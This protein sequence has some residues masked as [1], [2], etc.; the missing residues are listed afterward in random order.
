M[1]PGL[2]APDELRHCAMD[3]EADL[4]APLL[5]GDERDDAESS[6]T[7]K[8]S[9]E[10]GGSSGDVRQNERQT[11]HAPSTSY[12]AFGSPGDAFISEYSGPVLCAFHFH[13]H[14]AAPSRGLSDGSRSDMF[15]RDLLCLSGHILELFHR[16][17]AQGLFSPC[18][19]A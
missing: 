17:L 18:I 10:N 3:E 11:A 4:E 13:K 15:V 8:K 7:N 19:L 16:G 2:F 5:G 1:R 9:L 12:A 6:L 14:G